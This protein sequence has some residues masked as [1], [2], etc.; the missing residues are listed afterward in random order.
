MVPESE[1]T[2][3]QREFVGTQFPTPKG[4][5]LTVNGVSGKT[6]SGIAIFLVECNICSGDKELFPTKFNA[7]KGDLIRGQIP[8]GCSSK[9]NWTLVQYEVLVKRE[10]SRR[11]YIF[12]GF[13][14]KFKGNKTYLN[15]ENPETNNRWKSTNI[16][17]FLNEGVGDPLSTGKKRWSSHEREQ[18]IYQIF[19]TEGGVFSGWVN[20]YKN[21]YS[22]FKWVC[23]EGHTCKTS[24]NSFLF[25]NSRCKV[26][27]KEKMKKEGNFYGYFPH[28]KNE[29]DYLYIMNFNNKYIKIGRA[30]DIEKRINKRKTGIL[31]CSRFLRKDIK[32]LQVFTSNHQTVYDTE[33]WLHEELTDRGFYYNK[34]DG[35]WSIELFEVDC[36]QALNYLLKDVNLED[37]SD[38]FRD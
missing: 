18:Q 9:F 38:E 13:V 20:G 11:G 29:K 19:S 17:N 22:R 24:I 26:C 23:R 7:S 28:R 34:K 32:I 37:V 3:G 33:Q 36:L 30:F 16:N 31:D 5:M 10:S 27:Y 15:L 8:C 4:G 21:S 12:H 6:K 35:L 25:G 1:W 14:G 2:K